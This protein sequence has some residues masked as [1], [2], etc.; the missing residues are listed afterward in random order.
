MQYLFTNQMVLGVFVDQFK[1]A[2]LQVYSRTLGPDL[3]FKIWWIQFYF[4]N[5]GD[6]DNKI[7][8]ETI[9]MNL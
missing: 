6:T 8:N 3:T 5:I 9:K 2:Y 7:N 1:N 4:E